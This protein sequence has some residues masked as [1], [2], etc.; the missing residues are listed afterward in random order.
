M[1]EAAK[2]LLAK[3][4]YTPTQ[5]RSYFSWPGCPKK[6][7]NRESLI[8]EIYAIILKEYGITPEELRS[9]KRLY[10]NGNHVQARQLFLYLIRKYTGMT[11]TEITALVNRHHATM[12][13]SLSVMEAM[14]RVSSKY[15]DMVRGHCLY[16]EKEGASEEERITHLKQIGR[17]L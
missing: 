3:D 6:I 16:L 2:N 1:I 14:M 11:Y 12:N 7:T 15:R 13:H 17:Y 4:H 5:L 9:R 10:A 8:R